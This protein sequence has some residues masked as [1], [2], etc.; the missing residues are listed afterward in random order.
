M[1]PLKSGV[2]FKKL[3]PIFDSEELTR[4]FEGNPNFI[5][6]REEV[7]LGQRIDVA[8]FDYVTDSIHS[9]HDDV[10]VMLNFL[11]HLFP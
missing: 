7:D 1:N 11:G 3:E 10:E 9:S 8:I 6:G 4:V 5:V 2:F